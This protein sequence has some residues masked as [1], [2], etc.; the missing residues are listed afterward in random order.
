MSPA[1]IFNI[2]KLVGELSVKIAD[3]VHQMNEHKKELKDMRDRLDKH[4][5]VEPALVPVKD[6]IPA[7]IPSD[8]LAAPRPRRGRKK[9][10]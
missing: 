1:D 9:I 2:I 3:M 5:H 7:A 4:P 6:V 10:K 8:A